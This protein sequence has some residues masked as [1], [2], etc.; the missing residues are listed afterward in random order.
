MY[1]S[2]IV[3]LVCWCNPAD[4]DG[5]KLSLF[6]YVEKN[7]KRLGITWESVCEALEG[8]E[9]NLAF[10]LREKYCNKGVCIFIHKL[11]QRYFVNVPHTYK[12][13]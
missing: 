6:G 12:P 9:G 10:Q 4:V 13:H 7:H 2:I 3:L 5:Q 8:F 11:T 1:V